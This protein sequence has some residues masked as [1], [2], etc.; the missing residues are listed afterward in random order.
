MQFK[1]SYY[2]FTYV[3]IYAYVIYNNKDIHK[4]YNIAGRLKILITK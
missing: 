4:Q 1:I 3:D 2:F